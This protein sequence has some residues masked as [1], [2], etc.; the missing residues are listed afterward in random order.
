MIGS[1]LANR[2]QIEAELGRGGMGIVYKGYDTRLDRQVAIKILSSP[3]L[4]DEDRTHLF[5]EA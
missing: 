5:A 1:E 4:S 3:E 2:Y